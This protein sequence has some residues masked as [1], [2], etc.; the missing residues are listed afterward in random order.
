MHDGGSF[1]TANRPCLRDATG[2]RFER[3]MS[4]VMSKRVHIYEN[5]RE[6]REDDVEPLQ[7]RSSVR[8][9]ERRAP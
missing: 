2:G 6:A 7:S 4:K 9:S 5:R 3:R 1:N 8:V